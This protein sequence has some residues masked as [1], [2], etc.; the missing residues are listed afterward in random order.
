MPRIN[1]PTLAAHRAQQRT[2]LLDSWRDLLAERGYAAVSLADVAARAGVARTTVYNYFRDKPALLYALL[3]REV[4]EM[5]ARLRAHVEAAPTAA[6]AMARY[7]EAQM[8]EF[9]GNE[10]ASHDLVGELG[11]EGVHRIL[12]HLQPVWAMHADIVRRG[13]DAGEFRAVDVDAVVG[14]ITSCVGAER[15]PVASGERD[16]MVATAELVDFVLHA[17][18]AGDAVSSVLPR[19]AP[20]ASASGAAGRPTTR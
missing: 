14:L 9:A 1:A 13:V 16:P 10:V 2:V 15:L 12:E 18:G 19:P 11:P 7:L 5:M 4:A 8:F 20:P 17:L 6:E 3:E